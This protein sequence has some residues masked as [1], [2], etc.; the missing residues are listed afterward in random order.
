MS[1]PTKEALF[2]LAKHEAAHATVAIACGVPV[3][4]LRVAN[5]CGGCATAET[6][7][8]F[9]EAVITVAGSV[10]APQDDSDSC[11]AP[12]AIT[13]DDADIVDRLGLSAVGLHIATKQAAEILDRWWALHSSLTNELVRHGALAPIIVPWGRGAHLND[14]LDSESLRPSV[15]VP[16]DAIEFDAS[17]FFSGF[18]GVDDSDASPSSF[19]DVVDYV[20]E[21]DCC[22]RGCGE[23]EEEP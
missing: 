11:G 17:L 4:F 9:T 18:L 14:C 1:E 23:C 20:S 8:P 12:M 3:H 16:E 10:A 15:L 2:E 6:T 13:A 22:G 19:E 5:G 7:C 21:P